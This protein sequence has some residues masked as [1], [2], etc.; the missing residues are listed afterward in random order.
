MFYAC[1][2]CLFTVTFWPFWINLFFKSFSLSLCLLLYSLVRHLCCHLSLLT[3]SAVY[4][5]GGITVPLYKSGIASVSTTSSLTGFPPANIAI[6]FPWSTTL[7]HKCSNWVCLAC[8]RMPYLQSVLAAVSFLI[9]CLVWF[10]FRN[11]LLSS[12]KFIPLQRAKLSTQKLSDWISWPV[13]A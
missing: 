13:R 2:V 10:N 9:S 3:M 11:R 1:W 5:R 4:I 8:G 6:R 12:T 7:G